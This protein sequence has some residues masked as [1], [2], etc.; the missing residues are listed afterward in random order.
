[1]VWESTHDILGGNRKINVLTLFE[2][3]SCFLNILNHTYP[4]SVISA[5]IYKI[6]W[7]EVFACVHFTNPLSQ[8]ESHPPN[9]LLVIFVILCQRVHRYWEGGCCGV[10][11]GERT[12]LSCQGNDN[13]PCSNHGI[14]NV[15]TDHQQCVTFRA[16]G[17]WVSDLPLAMSSHWLSVWSHDVTMSTMRK[18]GQ[19]RCW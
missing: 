6:K 7:G 2:N 1:M 13:H 17:T 5:A 4:L 3:V 15:D 12:H 16:R 9:L 11:R 19:K 8:L 14:D 18:K 10:G